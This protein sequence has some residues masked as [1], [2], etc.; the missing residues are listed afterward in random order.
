MLSA[1]EGL[2]ARALRPLEAEKALFPFKLSPKFTGARMGLVALKILQSRTT[3]MHLT[4][5]TIIRE[6]EA[7]G[8]RRKSAERRVGI[9]CVRLGQSQWTAYPEN[10]KKPEITKKIK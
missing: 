5:L 8:K 7:R 6:T 10:N 9:G 4:S 1:H 3:G 2:I